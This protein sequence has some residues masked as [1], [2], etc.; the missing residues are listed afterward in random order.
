MGVPG[1]DLPL[2]VEDWAQW[3]AQEFEML[4]SVRDVGAT[5]DF[6]DLGGDSLQAGRLIGSIYTR[7]GLRLPIDVLFDRPTPAELAELVH[8]SLLEPR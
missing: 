6:F 3:L 2:A 7:C 4:L 1:A 5:D 8:H